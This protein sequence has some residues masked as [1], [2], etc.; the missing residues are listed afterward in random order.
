MTKEQ[1]S[2]LATTNRT[3]GLE[4]VETE[5]R[6]SHRRSL[7][8]ITV[9]TDWPQIHHITPPH[10]KMSPPCSSSYLAP[11]P[12][13]YGWG[14]FT[15]RS[16]QKGDI[17]EVAPM[18]LRVA[19]GDERAKIMKESALNNYHYEYWS[20]DGILGKVRLYD[21]ISFGPT[22][23][24]N[25]ENPGGKDGTSGPNIEQRKVG[26]EPDLENPERSV[27]IVYYALRDIEPGEELFVDYGPGWF[28][29]RGMTATSSVSTKHDEPPERKDMHDAMK[30]LSG[31][32]QLG[33]HHEALQRVIASQ[34][35]DHDDEMM[36]YRLETAFSLLP[37]SRVCFGGVTACQNISQGETIDFVP[38]MILQKSLIKATILESLAFSWDDVDESS[39]ALPQRNQTCNVY[40][41]YQ[42]DV[43]TTTPEPVM[44]RVPVEDSILFVLAGG[45]SMMARCERKAGSRAFNAVLHTE[46]DPCNEHGYC[47]RAIATRPI[48]AGELVVIGVKTRIPPDDVQTELCLTGQPFYSAGDD[49]RSM[50]DE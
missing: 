47:V 41:Q 5:S 20:W 25:H 17:V 9:R 6:A 34:E 36:P 32:I 37:T 50:S 44:L 39:A 43:D 35:V 46:E 19:L 45:I 12:N 13:G 38:A 29:G 30:A 10:W 31:K 28:E 23:Y 18:F 11:S 21:M 16:F 14:V 8:T 4:D 49:I 27:A 33:Y 40:V 3:N 24:Y 15:T 7:E 1:I 26:R 48:E 22:L 2:E 42:P